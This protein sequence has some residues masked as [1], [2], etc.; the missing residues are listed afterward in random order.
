LN[1]L[2]GLTKSKSDFE[3]A[4]KLYQDSLAVYMEMDDRKG[5]AAV[6]NNQGLMAEHYGRFE[7]AWIEGEN[8]SQAAAIEEALRFTMGHAAR[9]RQP[10]HYFITA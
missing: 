1:G 9:I 10:T 7:E 3:G 5:M 4:R 8:L 2:A 6:Y